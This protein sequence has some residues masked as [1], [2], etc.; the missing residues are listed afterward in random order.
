M[1]K[2]SAMKVLLRNDTNAKR[3]FFDRFSA[4]SSIFD[5]VLGCVVVVGVPR[6][7][8]LIAASRVVMSCVG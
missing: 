3:T 8:M 5:E 1:S 7:G 2:R 6:L 4:P